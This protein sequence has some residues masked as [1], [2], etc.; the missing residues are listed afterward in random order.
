M[1]GQW[2]VYVE[3]T[4]GMLLIRSVSRAKN[5]ESAGASTN[6]P[7]KSGSPEVPDCATTSSKSR[8]ITPA[9]PHIIHS[10]SLSNTSTARKASAVEFMLKMPKPSLQTYRA[11]QVLCV[12]DRVRLGLFG[13]SM[14]VV[15]STFVGQGVM[16]SR[17]VSISWS[18]VFLSCRRLRNRFEHTRK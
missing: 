16:R 13:M 15:E 14:H 2:S 18:S 5:G 1:Q 7:L 17:G 9:V 11:T 6:P 8:R 10:P 3:G 4:W 12:V